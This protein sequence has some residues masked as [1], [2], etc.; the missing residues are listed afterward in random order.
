MINVFELWCW[1]RL[2]N[3]PL[4]ARKSYQSILSEVNT[5]C[6][7]EGRMQKLKFQY[8]GIL[9]RRAELLEKTWCWEECRRRNDQQRIWWLNGVTDSTDMSLVDFWEILKYREFCSSW[10][11]RIRHYWR[12]EN[13]SN[14]LW[15]ELFSLV[16]L[17]SVIVGMLCILTKSIFFFTWLL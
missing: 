1:R 6:S 2:M 15:T 4:T 9:M 10:D 5:E 16:C 13:N 11:G 3:V 12:T 17:Y 7:L 8:F 14:L